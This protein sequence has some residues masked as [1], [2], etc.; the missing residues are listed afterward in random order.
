MLSLVDD[1]DNAIR[2]EREEVM[3]HFAKDCFRQ[4]ILQMHAAVRMDE[5]VSVVVPEE[6]RETE[7]LYIQVSVREETGATSSERGTDAF[8]AVLISVESEQLVA[9]EIVAID[10][11]E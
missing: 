11:A 1:R 3:S 7:T 9:V 10:G 4:A 8:T 2:A 5:I 6:R